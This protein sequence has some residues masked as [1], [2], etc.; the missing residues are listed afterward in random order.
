M[1]KLRFGLGWGFRAYAR[2]LLF[3]PL[4]ATCASRLHLF[5]LRLI[6]PRPHLRRRLCVCACILLDIFVL[7]LSLSL[8]LS[9]LPLDV[10]VYLSFF[11]ALLPS[12]DSAKEQ[13]QVRS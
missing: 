8:S 9:L 3:G 1:F 12:N 5:I 13:R 11:S 10:S 6:L 7:S 2:I 4:L